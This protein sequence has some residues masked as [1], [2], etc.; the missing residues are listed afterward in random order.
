MERVSEKRTALELT[1]MYI[2]IIYINILSDIIYSIEST[3]KREKFVS[4]T[5][6]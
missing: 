2:H 6:I 4:S 1:Y 3:K 5:Y